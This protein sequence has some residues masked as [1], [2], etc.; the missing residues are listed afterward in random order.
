MFKQVKSIIIWSLIYK[1]RKRLTLVVILLSMVLLSQWIYSDIV[2]YL[3]LI[4]KTEYLNYILP[5]KWLLIFTNIGVSAFLVLTIFRKDEKEIEKPKKS[6]KQKDE[7]DE[8]I[9]E[10]K[11]EKK[12]KFSDREKEFLNK[13]IRSEADI[14]MDR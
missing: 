12:E 1:F 2:E 9:V 3:T 4:E 13:K 7:K 11:I 8:N 14:L 10:E 5:A 6:F